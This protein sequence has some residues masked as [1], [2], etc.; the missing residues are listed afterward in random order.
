M[1][2]VIEPEAPQLGLF[3]LAQ[4]A[5]Q[6]VYSKETEAVRQRTAELRKSIDESQKAANTPQPTLMDLAAEAA[7]RLNDPREQVIAE[8]IKEKYKNKKAPQELIDAET[9]YFRTERT[10]KRKRAENSV[11]LL[12][13]RAMDILDN[14]HKKPIGTFIRDLSPEQKKELLDIMPGVA[15]ARGDDRGNIISR[16]AGSLD[17]GMASVVKPLADLTGLGSDSEDEIAFRKQVEQIAAQESDPQIPTDPW[18]ARGPLQA[19]EMAPWMVSV[20]KAGGMG[21]SAMLKLGGTPVAGSVG[22]TVGV[23][24]AAFPSMYDGEV[25]SLKELGM[26]D[27]WKLRL[28][29]AGTA[30]IGGAIESIIPNPFGAG[31]V[32]LTQGAMKAARSY[33]WD[34]VKKAPAELSEEYLQGVV[35]GLGDHI[36]QHIGSETSFDWGDGEIIKQNPVQRKSIADAFQ[37]GW[38]QMKEAALP[39]AFLLGVPAVGGAAASAARAQQYQIDQQGLPVAPQSTQAEEPP[40]TPQAEQPQAQ[41][42][43]PLPTEAPTDQQSTSSMMER[44]STLGGILSK[45]SVSRKDARENG[46]EGT[47]TPERTANARAE[48]QSLKEML[49]AQQN[50]GGELPPTT[51]PTP[52]TGVED[53][54]RQRRDETDVQVQ[55]QGQGEQGDAQGQ[56]LQ[57]QQE[58]VGSQTVTFKSGRKPMTV[59]EYLQDVRDRQGDFSGLKDALTMGRDNNENMGAGYL[60]NLPEGLTDQDLLNRISEMEM[61]P[62]GTKTESTETPQKQETETDLAAK[63]RD[64]FARRRG[65]KAPAETPQPNPEMLPMGNIS[66]TTPDSKMLPMGNKNETPE[67]PI[68]VMGKEAVRTQ[69]FTDSNNVQYELFE[70]TDGK[71]GF[72]RATDVDS[73]EVIPGGLTK[74]PSVATARKVYDAIPESR[75][76]GAK[77]EAVRSQSTPPAETEV[78]PNVPSPATAEDYKQLPINSIYQSNGRFSVKVEPSDRPSGDTLHDSYGEAVKQAK[79]NEDEIREREERT[80]KIAKQEADEQAKKQEGIDAYQGFLKDNPMMFGKAKAT[81]DKSRNY[82]GKAVVL[83]ELI[84]QKVTDGWTVNDKGQLESPDGSFLDSNALTKTGINY[85]RYLIGGDQTVPVKKKTLEDRARESLKKRGKKKLS[86]SEVDAEM[87]LI[88]KDD[89]SAVAIAQDVSYERTQ[90]NE[91]DRQREFWRSAKEKSNPA[92]VDSLRV[93]DMDQVNDDIKR[94]RASY[95]SIKQVADEAVKTGSL[96][97]GKVD[98]LILPEMSAQQSESVEVNGE[99]NK[100]PWQMTFEEYR[101]SRLKYADKNGMSRD[102]YQESY[103]DEALR[104][105]YLSI[106]QDPPR[107]AKIDLR[108]YDQLPEALQ[109]RWRKFIAS[110]D[111][112]LNER[113]SEASKQE[114]A[115]YRPA[116]DYIKR[117]IEEYNVLRKSKEKKNAR[118]QVESGGLNEKDFK[119]DLKLKDM[120]K[121]LDAPFSS[122]ESKDSVIS[123]LNRRKDYESPANESAPVTFNQLP[124]SRNAAG[125][126]STI[127]VVAG[128]RKLI[129]ERSKYGSSEWLIKEEDTYTGKV[130]KGAPEKKE[131][132]TLVSGIRDTKKAKEVAQRIVDGTFDPDANAG[133]TNSEIASTIKSDPKRKSIFAAV[134]RSKGIAT[135]GRMLIKVNDKDRDAIL[136]SIGKTEDARE[137]N[138]DTIISDA[139]KATGYRGNVMTPI[140]YRGGDISKRSVVLKSQDGDIVV[141]DKALHDTVLKKYPDAVPYFSEKDRPIPYE[142]GN[143]VVAVLMPLSVKMDDRLKSLTKGEYDFNEK[144]AEQ[145]KTEVKSKPDL[146]AK[147]EVVPELS[148]LDKAVAALEKRHNAKVTLVDVS[149]LSEDHQ[150]SADFIESRGKKIQFYTTTAKNSGGWF[151]PGTDVILVN[152]EAEGDI[153]WGIVGHELAHETGLDKVIPVD[154]T[155]L[156]A[157]MDVYLKTAQPKYQ[158]YLKKNRGQWEQEGRAQIIQRFFQDKGF[159]DSLR[160]SN[161]TMWEQ[162]RE[163]IMK[164]LG[165]WAPKDEARKQVL[166]ELRSAKVETPDQSP[167]LPTKFGKESYG[168][169][170]KYLSQFD[171]K[172][173]AG[174]R[175]AVA[176]ATVSMLGKIDQNVLDE[177]RVMVNGAK[178]YLDAVDTGRDRLD[179]YGKLTND[180]EDILVA[181]EQVLVESSDVD[182]DTPIPE[183]NRTTPDKDSTTRQFQNERV[184]AARKEIADAEGKRRV[185]QKEHDGLRSNATKKRAEVKKDIAYINSRIQVIESGIAVDSASETIAKI[186]DELESPRSYDHYLAGMMAWHRAKADLADAQWKSQSMS[187]SESQSSAKADEREADRFKAILES[188]AKQIASD[189]G[190]DQGDASQVALAASNGLTVFEDRSLS[191]IV[192]LQADRTRESRVSVEIGKMYS[193]GYSSKQSLTDEQKEEFKKQYKESSLDDKN[194]LKRRLE[195]DTA[196]N[197]AVE[198]NRA[199]AR[200]VEEEERKV[201]EAER[202]KQEQEALA[203]DRQRSRQMMVQNRINKALSKRKVATEKVYVAQKDK[204]G[205]VNIN[206]GAFSDGDVKGEL[207]PNGLLLH[208]AFGEDTGNSY[209]VT[210][211]RSGTSVVVTKKSDAQQFISMAELLGLDFNVETEPD[212]KLPKM[213]QDR[214]KQVYRSWENE[215]IEVLSEQDKATVFAL[216]KPAET[217]VDADMVLTG[218]DLGANGFPDRSKLTDR[219]LKVVKDLAESVPEFSYDPV[220]TVESGKMVYRDGFKFTFE[221]T[222][223]NLHPSELTNGQTIGINLEDLGIKRSTPQDVVAGMLSNQGLKVKKNKGGDV[224]AGT[225]LSSVSVQ[226]GEQDNDWSVVGGNPA[227]RGV[228]LDVLRKIRWRQP[229]QSG[230]PK[231][232]IE[233]DQPVKKRSERK[234]EEAEA[235]KQVLNEKLDAFLKIDP[236]QLNMG[237]D[238]KKLA[239]AVDLA[240]AA[241]DYGITKFDQ[242]VS[243]VVER[244]G[245]SRAREM[246][247]YIEASAREAGFEDITSVGDVIDVPAK[248]RT[249][250]QPGDSVTSIKNEVVNELR[251]RRGVPALEDVAAQTQQEWLDIAESRLLADR[252]LGDR[253]VT[254]ITANPR[255]LSNIE[256]AVMQVYYRQLNNEFESAS[257][258]LFDANDSG[259]SEAAAQAQVSADILLKKLVD[260]EDATKA[261]GRE[262]GRAGVARQIA[263]AK[264]FSLVAMM[265]RAR[266]ANTGN[267]LSQDQ[268]AEITKMAKQ[269]AELEGKLS[270]LE[271]EAADRERNRRV[272]EGI[273]ADKQAAKKTGRK[274]TLRKKA[275]DAVAAFKAEWASLFT[276]GAI[277]DPKREA[278]KWDKIVRAAGKVVKAYV[279]LG[280]NTFSEFISSVR[281]DLGDVADN[282]SEAFQEAWDAA[283]QAGEIPSPELDD[284]AAISRFAKQ[285]QRALVESGITEREEVVSGVHEALKEILPDITRRETMDAMSGYGQFTMLSQDEIS[286]TIRDINGQLQQLAKLED[287]QSGQAPSK[288]GVERRTPSD[289]E[290]RLIQLVNEAKRR[291][292]FKVTDPAAQ[293]K[294]A[295]EAAKTAT[296]NRISDLTE[297]IRRK[298]KIVRSKTELT[299]DAELE[300]LRK[301]RDELLVIHKSLFP[302]PSATPEQRIATATKALDRAI[303]EVE[304]QIQTGDVMPKKLSPISTPEID[305]KR[306]R[307]NEL[308][309]QREAIQLLLNPNMKDEQAAKAY[310]A[311]LLKQLADYKQRIANQEFNPKP[312]KDPRKLSSEE[313]VLKKQIADVKHDFFEKAAEYRRA[314]MSPIEKAWDYT[315]EMA[316]LSRAAMT[317]IDLSAVFRQGGTFVFGHP[318]IAAKASKEMLKALV[319]QQSEYN[320]VEEI[321]NRTN[322]QLYETAGL[323]ITEDEGKLT[324]Q[325]EAYMGRWAKK[326]PGV[327]ASARAY[328]TFLNNLRADMF[329]YMVSN[330][331]RSGQVTLDEA[332]V[333]A[334]FINVATGRSEFGKFNQAAANLN[335]VFF[336]PR[337]VASRFQYLAMPFYLPFTKASLRVKTAIAKEYARHTAGVVSFLTLSVALGSLLYDDD[338]EEKPTVE[339][340]D[341]R[342]SD[343]LKLRIGETRIDPMSGLSQSVVLISRVLSGQTKTT[344]GEVNPLRGKDVKYGGNTTISTI[345]NFLRTKLAPIPG[346]V[347]T[348]TTVDWNT[349]MGEDVVGQEVAFIANPFKPSIVRDMFVPLSFR[350]ISDTMQSRGIPKGTA[351]SILGLLGMGLGTYGPR[352]QYMSGTDEERKKQ[353]AKYLKKIEF[354]SPDPEYS[355]LLTVDQM[356]QVA[357]GRKTHAEDLAYKI[358]SKSY[359]GDIRQE[360]ELYGLTAQSLRQALLR[361]WKRDGGT[362][363][364][365]DATGMNVRKKSVEDRMNRINKAFKQ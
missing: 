5:Q 98:K 269:I 59:D 15:M 161:P 153:L 76:T 318:K 253:I 183:F 116:R 150:E 155:E 305:A 286:R 157:E 8:K 234:T 282:S 23:T 267:P 335:M 148:S 314:N 277:Y 132:K 297:E 281:K 205:P 206:K 93:G 92:T 41:Q 248:P 244:I 118:G 263:L 40:V 142:F 25:Q 352:T 77:P 176:E 303:A 243:M 224:T 216:S 220:F 138:V 226:Q 136:K 361:Y 219:G 288:T 11:P 42:A 19:T 45:G 223:F 356:D 247:S 24:A 195:I 26:V 315:K 151:L 214:A 341:S 235:K 347:I 257:E 192:K 129:M 203:K 349:G 117:K 1:Q 362:P 107:D 113:V 271:Q 96:P 365:P 50:T 38:E 231:T 327:A 276:M 261:A 279:E 197:D 84:E 128:E 210:H 285:V 364:E 355:D 353:F 88:A 181:I 270:K 228:V 323:N 70:S 262:W 233:T 121:V 126:S 171:L 190:L 217:T 173:D 6:N 236:T 16:A 340:S 83:R 28:L 229:G 100:Q 97:Q 112:Q 218:D 80:K 61:V 343:F 320:S 342:S 146:P 334:K 265:R 302:K 325:E 99:T 336:A 272:D 312:K 14:L 111:E 295:L 239:E 307:L 252:S 39:M 62:M 178:S 67:T 130:K 193:P 291:G 251:E 156:Q 27:D 317:S 34:S 87:E 91:I 326:V 179:E 360:A 163:S 354:N 310:K 133:L 164:F 311:S 191:D 125:V 240:F 308:K 123:N 345:G 86:Q 299:P 108:V 350:E 331:G 82:K 207:Y 363:D 149:Q 162:I 74:Y 230:D 78:A 177:S 338:D 301:R 194:W 221:P 200:K 122:M 64:E 188:R 346:A 232:D 256:V 351:I 145:P 250:P 29:A 140:G 358:S 17:K 44:L 143:E 9:E 332:K 241:L 63:M 106:I 245:E 189:Q 52:T 48:A 199:E 20:A 30:T 280:V 260:L 124:N 309:E 134:L 158:E 110:V 135:D 208:P 319:S 104:S 284:V 174:R 33:L 89:A 328:S 273:E 168:D 4:Q 105:Q 300:D 246:S 175:N 60:P 198:S 109:A 329:D 137:I 339:F 330:L 114:D 32:P 71:S 275:S 316:H 298:E 166:D 324:R 304:R 85:A 120:L 81:L 3:E 167:K 160:R 196:V 75:L 46:I 182:V 36:A 238:P 53:E 258:S 254:E 344:K 289:E 227:T 222:V 73:G 54:V 202:T 95:E 35:S 278:E 201:A 209:S 2:E 359:D 57:G 321:R 283:K 268:Q 211:A 147:P 90:Q 337:Y 274:S 94:G 72:V 225:G 184:E 213:L 290:R 49:D 18:Y 51:G 357:K 242:Y 154:S 21:Q 7:K 159:R 102:E 348:T 266:V 56:V 55:T 212:G 187:R 306:A 333:I 139:S 322:G 12:R 37:K 293:L 313:L 169:V 144:P 237:I 13:V 65:E 296:R 119:D 215:D 58:E 172:T 31:N 131:G 287:M 294:T 10:A 141:I 255:N 79:R 127:E 69:S 103:P 152:S 264:D 249:Q 186:E 185:K 259:D 170:E 165:T 115:K 180:T 22:S 101:E 47:S 292:G 66:E 43:P 68:K 204:G